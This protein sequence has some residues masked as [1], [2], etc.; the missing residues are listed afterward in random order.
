MKAGQQKCAGTRL[1]GCKATVVT[2]VLWVSGTLLL[3]S[4]GF[5]RVREGHLPELVEAK[6]WRVREKP[7]CTHF[8]GRG[9]H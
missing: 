8:S 5:I 2:G 6:V 3:S 7:S 4:P 9:L 1:T